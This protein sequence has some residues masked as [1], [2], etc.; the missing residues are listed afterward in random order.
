MKTTHWVALK[1]ISRNRPSMKMVTNMNLTSI[2]GNKLLRNQVLIILYL[3]LW[4]NWKALDS[5][6][7]NRR[8]CRK[9]GTNFVSGRIN[10]QTTS[11][12][13]LTISRCVENLH[14]RLVLALLACTV[15]RFFV[16][17][18]KFCCYID[19]S[20]GNLDII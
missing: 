19:F 1:I 9:L 7:K 11:Q 15:G 10:C 6:T 5:T 4:N 16:Y 2:K 12:V 17:T 18:M 8:V 3:S 20:I 14:F 13:I